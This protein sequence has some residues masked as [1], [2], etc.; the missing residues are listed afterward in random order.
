MKPSRNPETDNLHHKVCCPLTADRTTKDAPK[1][2][3]IIIAAE[4][5]ERNDQPGVYYCIAK[6]EISEKSSDSVDLFNRDLINALKLFFLCLIILLIIFAIVLA[7]RCKRKKSIHRTTTNTQPM[8][9]FESWWN[10]TTRRNL[11]N[12]TILAEPSRSR[13]DLLPE[14]PCHPKAQRRQS[15]PDST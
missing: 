6:N 11:M 8:F 3:N 14:Q 7:Y 5:E 10:G 13:D 12:E 1:H 4:K 9:G 15:H 2:T